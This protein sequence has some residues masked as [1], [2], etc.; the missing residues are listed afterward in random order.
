[1]SSQR[2][3]MAKIIAWEQI[4][5]D[6]VSNEKVLE[7]AKVFATNFLLTHMTEDQRKQLYVMIEENQDSNEVMQ[8]VDKSLPNFTARVKQALS[9]EL[10]SL[11][12]T[13]S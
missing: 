12:N 8:F 1:M 5:A 11:V 13:T 2:K 6:E 3:Q 7:F 4:F 10:A 9:E